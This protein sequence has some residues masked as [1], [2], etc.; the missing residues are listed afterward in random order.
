MRGEGAKQFGVALEGH[1]FI[2]DLQKKN[3]TEMSDEGKDIQNQSPVENRKRT[4]PVSWADEN[5]ADFKNSKKGAFQGKFNE[6]NAIDFKEEGTD[7]NME[8][9]LEGGE[10]DIAD[11]DGVDNEHFQP[12]KL[13]YEH[14]DEYEHDCE[15]Y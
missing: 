7:P 5:S 4:R 10:F 12:Y 6:G 8:D 2:A 9:E 15:E 1:V 3:N 14:E 11:Q 13:W